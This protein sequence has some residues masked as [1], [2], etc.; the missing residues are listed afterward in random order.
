[1]KILTIEIDD[2]IYDEIKT[3]VTE[4]INEMHSEDVSAGKIEIKES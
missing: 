2:D 3:S 4:F 1:M